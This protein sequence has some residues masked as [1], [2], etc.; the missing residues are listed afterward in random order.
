MCYTCLIRHFHVAIWLRR[1]QK[2]LLLLP[3][4]STPAF[5]QHVVSGLACEL[6]AGLSAIKEV[7]QTDLVRLEGGHGLQ[8]ACFV[9][10][11]DV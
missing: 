5:L 6:S 10:K 11:G 9:A 8:A 7:I 2:Q 3:C 4:G 1:A